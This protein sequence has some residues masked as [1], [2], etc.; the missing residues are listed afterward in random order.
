LLSESDLAML[1]V[2]VHT[3]GTELSNT[4]PNYPTE[5]D[6]LGKLRLTR[7]TDLRLESQRSPNAPAL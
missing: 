3:R 4:W 6:T 1:V 2:R 7:H 5:T